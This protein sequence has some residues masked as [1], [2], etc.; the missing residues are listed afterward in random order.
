[1]GLRFLSKR[2]V[3]LLI[4]SDVDVNAVA[5]IRFAILKRKSLEH[6]RV[7]IET[8]HEFLRTRTSIE[9]FHDLH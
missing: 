6:H 9:T 5:T 2:C 8:F 3:A 7:S 4:Q 1:M